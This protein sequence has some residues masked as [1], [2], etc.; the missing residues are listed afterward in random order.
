M[1]TEDM[2]QQSRKVNHGLNIKRLRLRQGLKQ[3]TMASLVNLSQQ[4]V[5]RYE[6]MRE[7]DNEMLERFAKALKVPVELIETMEEGDS[8]L[9]FVENN[10]FTETDNK[11]PINNMIGLEN[12]A[13][14]YPIEQVT[15][16]LERILKEEKANN[17]ALEKRLTDLEEYLKQALSK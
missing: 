14:N 10:T 1:E 7:I 8:P 5:S 17:A 16:L 12:T 15:E 3:D 9:I 11:A 6:S 4:T 13:N 2:L